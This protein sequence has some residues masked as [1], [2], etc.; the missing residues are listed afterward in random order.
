MN[1]GDEVELILSDIKSRPAV[2]RMRRF[3]QHGR[4]STYEHCESVA[5]LSRDI[6]RL[7]RLGCDLRVLLHGAMLHDFFLYDWHRDDGGSHRLHGFTHAKRASRNAK[8]L[9]GADERVCRV[10]ESHMWPL[11]ITRV[12]R[13]REAWVVCLADKLVSL[14][15]TLFRR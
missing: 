11:N 9:L 10:I 13:S 3:I 4:V 1:T 6:D 14:Y 5:R 2:R 12:P 15:E 8:K 7:F